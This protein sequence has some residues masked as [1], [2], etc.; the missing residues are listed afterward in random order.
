MNKFT[1]KNIPNLNYGIIHSQ[2]GYSDGVSIV[3][4]QA[5]EIMKED[6]NIPE[7]NIYYLVGKARRKEF[8]ITEKNILR[9]KYFINKMVLKSYHK[10]LNGIKKK[11]FERTVLM[12]KKCI[13]DF[14]EEN[15]IDVIVAHNMSHP[16]NF[17]TSLAISRYYKEA[18]KKGERTPKYLLWWH[19]SHLERK[20]YDNPADDIQDYLLEGVPGGF[21]EYIIFINSLQFPQAEK[22]YFS[23]LEKKYS[24][25]S[26]LMDFHHDIIYNT[27]DRMIHSYQDLKNRETRELKKEF[28]NDFN[29][30]RLLKKHDPGLKKTLFVLQHTR[31]VPRKR[32]D[33]ALEFV[34][35]LREFLEK[36]S[37]Y[38]TL[39][40]F[41]SGATGL[42]SKKTRVEL[43]KLH[44]S[45]SKKYKTNRVFLVF[46]SEENGRS[47]IGFYNFPR[48]F[49]SLGGISTYFSEIEGFGNNL[50]E[51]M[52]SGLI[53]VVYTYPVF[54]KDL[55][56]FN[57]KTI[58]LDKFEVSPECLQS[59]LEI[60][61][62]EE[63]RKDW[64]EENLKILDESFRHKIIARKLKKAVTK[65]RINPC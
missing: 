58:S 24:H 18:I 17:I 41:V 22:R 54:K 30:R 10:G 27:A 45:L 25:Y 19:D 39:Y 28:L 59:V 61:E 37:K 63:K 26:E 1:E 60:I 55:E 6:M 15:K 36:E 46:A 2:H 38:D 65:K 16:V 33:F 44:R 51:V 50:L 9:D 40:F 13:K 12:A 7:E 4:Q 32:I 14:V 62:D 48:I 5:E 11:L 3:M 34:F 8:N 42:K 29:V 56:K 47:R 43:R 49:A 23:L 31:V 35:E 53:P 64:A 52:A 57:F 21:V 20:E